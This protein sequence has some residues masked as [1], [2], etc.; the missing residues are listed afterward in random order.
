MINEE[1]LKLLAKDYPTKEEVIKEIINL[2]AILNLPKG[3][4]Y[5]I[6]DI[7]GEAEQFYHILNNCS[8]IIKE[9]VEKN[10]SFL[11]QQV[12]SELCFLVYYPKLKISQVKKTNIDMKKWYRDYLHYLIVLA[13][14]LSVNYTRSRVRKL[15][16]KAYS[17]ILDELLHMQKSNDYNTDQ[18]YESI[19]ES[20]IEEDQ[21]YSFLISI[22]QLIKKLAVDQLHIVGDI[23]DR[24]PRPDEIVDMLIDYHNVDIQ[25]GN[26]DILWMGAAS[27]NPVCIA[28]VVFNSIKYHNSQV[29]EMGYGISL[30]KLYI[31]AKRLYP[32]L[33]QHD[34]ALNTI[35]MIMFKL[36][37][38]LIKKHPEYQMDDKLYL[39]KINNDTI[40][41]NHIKYHLDQNLFSTILKE[42][43][44]NKLNNVEKDI[45]QDL[46]NSFQNSKRLHKHINFIYEKG[47]LYKIQNNN[48]IYHGCIPLTKNGKL[49]SVRFEGC[50][51]KGK[52][53]FDFLDKKIRKAYYSGNQNCIDL[54]WFLWSSSLSPLCGRN[55]KYFEH[56]Y[57]KELKCSHEENDHY[58]TMI[59]D[60][61]IVDMILHEFGIE[62]G[63]I[64]NGHIPIK[65]IQGESPIRCNGKVII[66]DGGFCKAYHE[67][68]GTSG[69]TLVY[70][71]KELSLRM[72]KGFEN[73]KD[74]IG[75]NNDIISLKLK[76]KS[77]EK[78]KLILDC[79]NGK[80]IKKELKSLHDLLEAY[81]DGSIQCLKTNAQP[82][83][84]EGINILSIGG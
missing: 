22:C 35:A 62:D 5:F 39:D 18:Y 50:V 36:E 32:D 63:A 53:Y 8:G 9:Q 33:N 56:F 11:T 1:Y 25:W 3:T 76:I 70:D 27:L 79:D 74:T 43:P 68:T 52:E 7:H 81:R 61:Q 24:G 44:K 55:V 40:E 71:S 37:D 77:F 23:F 16:P 64:I 12:Q 69:Y 19:I 65:V 31:L 48:L 2:K 78:R 46:I 42:A 84:E 34:A 49:K 13:K 21:C 51:L 54:M 20:L 38:Q 30:R 82:S 83:Y 58:Y 4:E 47:S 14:V 67:K 80:K 73:L 10:F 45:I 29:L 26:H 59:Q 15:F 72:H 60:K 57:I 41:V 6:S 28:G 75:F 17:Y 66:I